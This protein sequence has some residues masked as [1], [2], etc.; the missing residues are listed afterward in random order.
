MNGN[1]I[2][3]STYG[4]DFNFNFNDVRL[5][6]EWGNPLTMESFAEVDFGAISIK[7]ILQNVK[8]IITTPIWSVPLDRLFGLDMR[9]IDEPI[10]LARHYIIPEI[11]EKIQRFERR[12]SVLQIDFE[13]EP[14]TGHLIP[15]LQIRALNETY[16]DREPY[17][18][19]HAFEPALDYG[20][21]TRQIARY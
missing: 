13:G 5:V 14:L 6:D 16:R 2:A 10:N 17:Q 11:L 7:E 21:R 9:I 4:N 20:V 19:Q 15:I 3:L 18:V 12:A 1:G 8:M